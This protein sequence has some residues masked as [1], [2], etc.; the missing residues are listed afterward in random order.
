[1]AGRRR[2]H[3]PVAARFRLDW[4]AAPAVKPTEGLTAATL[5]EDVFGVGTTLASL[6]ELTGPDA[7][8]S[9]A[10]DFVLVP[11]AGAGDA[12]GAGDPDAHGADVP[13]AVHALTTRTLGLLQQWQ[14]AERLG[15]SR[16]VFVTTGA[17]AAHDT[18]TVRDLAAG[19]AWGLVRSAQSENPDRFVLL[20]LDGA[21]APDTLRALLPDLPGLL[22]SGDAQFAVREGTALVGRLERLTTA[23]GLLAPT[24]TPWRLDTTGKGSLDNL[25]LAPCP[26][27]LQPL[28]AHEVRID[29]EAAGLNFRDVLNALGMYPGESGPM[30]TEAA[31]VVT[32]VGEAVTGLAPGDRVLGTVPGGFGPVV[33]ADQHY[34]IQVPEGWTMRDAA[35]VP[36]V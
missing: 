24:G 32:A 1:P 17:V 10:P 27:V 2:L 5:G 6:T 11:L 13:A 19:A 22:G 16:L 21:D 30:G 34:V 31:G 18:E 29:V 28:G 15:Y 4:T 23:P 35:S 8:P 3:G 33:V 25:V 12:A 9:A 26:E 14:A 7:D 36:L 20:D